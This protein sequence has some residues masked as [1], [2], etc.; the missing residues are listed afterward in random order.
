[1]ISALTAGNLARCR[2]PDTYRVLAMESARPKLEGPEEVDHASEDTA[3]MTQLSQQ[4]S[5]VYDAAGPSDFVA[6]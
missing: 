5:L 6:E 3:N 1:M 4:V 2:L